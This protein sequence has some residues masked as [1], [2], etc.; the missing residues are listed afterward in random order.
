MPV[1]CVWTPT[2]PFSLS[3]RGETSLAAGD[4]IGNRGGGMFWD[5]QVQ[6]IHKFALLECSFVT[7]F[8]ARTMNNLAL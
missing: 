5:Q 3:H 7:D 6:E 1:S 2:E 8:A 4:A